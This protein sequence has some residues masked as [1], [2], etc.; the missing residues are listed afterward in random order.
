VSAIRGPG[1]GGGDDLHALLLYDSEENLRAGAVPYVREGLDRGE[2]VVAVVSAETEWMLR[3]ALR[4]E[5]GSVNWQADAVSYL[6]LGQMFEGFRQFLAAQRAAGVAMRL[7]AEN[8]T[9]GDPERL[10]AYLRCEAMAN[11]VFTPYGYR[12][13]CLYD[14]RAYTPEVLRRVLQV[15]PRLLGPGGHALANTDYVAPG[16]YLARAS[17]VPPPAPDMPQYD[18]TIVGPG[19]LVPL[20]RALRAW[21]GSRGM[22]RD[23]TDSVMI[24]VGE[25]LTNAFLH[26]APPVRLRAWTTSRAARVQVQ[27]RGGGPIPHTAGYRRPAALT[28]PGFGLWLARQLTDVLT[29]Y[30]GPAGT[31]VD[32][33][34][35]IPHMP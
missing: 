31:T 15:H 8:D 10:A 24:A 29:T 1:D 5:S 33:R 14:T 18:K 2:S 17:A 23:A 6:C 13:V 7:L 9:D 35:S 22:G 34:F 11:E 4:G 32:L 25:V 27:D 19:E 12:W 21:C 3:S 16:D 28:D 26:G 20:R 30:S